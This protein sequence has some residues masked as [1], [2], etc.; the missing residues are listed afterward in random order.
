[1]PDA[2][3]VFATWTGACNGQGPTCTLT[4]DASTSTNAVFGLV[5]AST[6]TT[7]TTTT[8]NT[9]T[10]A[11]TTVTPPNAT[12]ATASA[13][14]TVTTQAPG[15]GTTLGARLVY[16]AVLGRGATRTLRVRLR[17]SVLAVAVLRLVRDGRQRLLESYAVKPVANELTAALPT[18]LAP[19]TYHLTVGLRD[20][21]GHA[22]L[23]TATVLM[24]A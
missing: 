9:T 2:G 12:P 17:A 16:A 7:T 15:A 5:G 11:T 14:P 19:G 21:A 18:G 6:K 23:V 10:T 24:F 1:V 22:K 8:A 3:A 13:S 20:S 4:I